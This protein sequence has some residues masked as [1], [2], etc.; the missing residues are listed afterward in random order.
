M[1]PVTNQTEAGSAKLLMAAAMC[2]YGSIGLFRRAI[3]VSSASLAMCRGLIGVTVL[4][5]YTRISGKASDRQA[6]RAN[7]IKLLVSGA[8]IGFNWILLFEAYNY[9][10][11][12]VASLCYY[13]EPVLVIL[14]SPLV[15]GERV[16]R[17]KL[18]CVAVT[19]AGMVLVSGITRTG[20]TGGREMIGV[21]LGLGAAA[22]Y[23]VVVLLNKKLSPISPYDQTIWQ[24]ASAGIVLI[25]YLLLTGDQTLLTAAPTTLGLILLVGVVHTG[26]AYAMYFGSMQGL[27][28]QTIALYSYIDPILAIFLSVLILR[29]PLSFTEGIGAVLVIGAMLAGEFV[30]A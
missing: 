1:Q 30:K 9:T 15:L 20:F 14:L 23:A 26:I 19:L 17:A 2:I 18:L 22:L 3:P 25:P 24:L 16:S 13:M 29:E 7:R 27:R 10:T 21:A 11:V 12:A 5:L 6:I 4:L 8:L 28:A